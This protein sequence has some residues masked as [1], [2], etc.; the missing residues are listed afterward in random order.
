MHLK[1]GKLVTVRLRRDGNCFFALSLA[2]IGNGSNHMRHKKL[3][4]THIRHKEMRQLFHKLHGSVEE[5][6]EKNV[7]NM[8]N[9]KTYGI[10]EEITAAAHLLNVQ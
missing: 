1:S 4:T 3:I 6:F 9:V 8:S 7:L 10:I 2:F 5:D